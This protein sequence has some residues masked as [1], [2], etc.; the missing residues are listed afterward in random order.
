MAELFEDCIL[1]I[2]DFYAFHIIC[3]YYENHVYYYIHNNT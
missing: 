3:K 1:L 2:D